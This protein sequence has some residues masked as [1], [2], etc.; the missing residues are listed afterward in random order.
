MRAASPEP[1]SSIATSTRETA[2]AAVFA[3][4]PTVFTFSVHG[5]RNF[6][7]RKFPSDLD[8]ELDDGAGDDPYLDAVET[9]VRTALSRANA[10][11]AFYLAG[12]D[13]YVGDRLGRLAV[14]PAA[15]AERDRLV[16]ASCSA[17]GLPVAVAMAGGYARDID[18]TVAIQFQTVREAVR[19]QRPMS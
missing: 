1:S 8:L 12:A 5:A 13:P 10:D 2:P 18:D 7:L 15:L 11:L 6:P 4:D 17:A 3:D 9:G 19:W 16:F 14:S